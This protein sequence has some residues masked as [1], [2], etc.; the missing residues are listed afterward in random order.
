[1]FFSFFCQK[2]ASTHIKAEAKLGHF[3]TAWLTHLSLAGSPGPSSLPAA[4]LHHWW[5][6]VW[7]FSDC[8]SS[9]WSGSGHRLLVETNTLQRPQTLCGPNIEPA[10]VR[11]RC[12]SLLSAQRS[13]NRP[14]HGWSGG[15]KP[16]WWEGRARWLRWRRCQWFGR[17]GKWCSCWWRVCRPLCLWTDCWCCLLR[18]LCFF[19]TQKQFTLRAVFLQIC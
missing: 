5:R 1:M 11:S 17:W 14:A 7:E 13:R 16:A 12:H 6:P 19:T 3:F 10:G 15:G 2:L 18:N 4:P 9:V 8:W